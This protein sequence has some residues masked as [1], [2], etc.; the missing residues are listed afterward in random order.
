MTS[1]SAKI[2]ITF[3][4]SNRGRNTPSFCYVFPDSVGVAFFIVK[5]RMQCIITNAVQFLEETV[6]SEW[7]TTG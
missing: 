7:R 4:K 6:A 2:L 3:S 5:L 1:E